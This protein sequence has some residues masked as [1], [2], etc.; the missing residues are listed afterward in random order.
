MQPQVR[1]RVLALALLLA[2][3]ALVY[4]VFV[5]PWFTAPLR[6]INQDIA[7]LQ[8]RGQRVQ[9][10]LA[11]A[12]QVRAR[13]ADVRQGVLQ[14]PGFLR[15][16]TAEA[17]AASLG[18]RLQ[19]VV[20][21]ASPGQRACTI[22]NRTPVP[23]SGPATGYE[24]VGMQV[25][26]RCGVDE[27]ARVLQL[28]EGGTPRVFVENLNILAQRYQQSPEETGTGLDVSFEL[29]G[30]LPPESAQ[31]AGSDAAPD[32]AMPAARADEDA[33]AMPPSDEAAAPA[34]M[35]TDADAA[36]ESTPFDGQGGAD[37]GS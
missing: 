2:V 20:E 22:S 34:G 8:E 6:A 26:L 31:A 1:D 30:Y 14:R 25:R 37:D 4:L 29:V 36:V 16:S 33:S 19:D 13:L 32:D 17:A 10:Q 15:E 7:A 5:H 11:Q 21:S 28:L 24:R 18:S 12:P 35:Q 3:L 23:G 9:A 27:M